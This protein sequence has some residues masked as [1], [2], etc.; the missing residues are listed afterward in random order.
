MSDAKSLQVQSPTETFIANELQIDVQL[1]DKSKNEYNTTAIS[2]DNKEKRNKEVVGHQLR[3]NTNNHIDDKND[4]NVPI[5]PEYDASIDER[6]PE[7]VK[8][9]TTPEGGKL[10]L[11]GTAHFSVDSQNDVSTIIRAV[12]PD[13]V[14]VELCKARINIININEDALY[15]YSSKLSLR[16]LTEILWDYGTSNGLL[17]IVLYKVIAS[18][19]KE[20]GMP[21]GGEFRTA[22]EE[23]KKIPNCIIQL[24]DRSINITF[25]RALRELSWWETIKLAWI[26]IWTDTHIDKEGVEEYK[27]KS[28]IEELITKLRE[29]YPAIERT[30]VKERDIYLTYHLQMAVMAQL[31]SKGSRPPRVV[32]VVGIGHTKGILENWGKVKESDIWPIMRVPP[33]ALSSK[34]LKFTIKVSLLGAVLYVGYKVIPMPSSSTLQSMKSS[35]QG[36]LK[37]SVKK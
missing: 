22:F 10:Y 13:I 30:F 31:N 3:F 17:H 34:I 36:L 33:Q 1:N 5:Q 18:V 35:I 29:E 37:V 24:A 26:F 4:T 2:V 8:L 9:I 20:L 25:Q 14:V 11:V 6:L 27:K 32:G 7:T 28:V 12:Q 21:P 19:I 16:N 23:V 15:H